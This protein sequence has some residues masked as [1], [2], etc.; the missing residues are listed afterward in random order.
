MKGVAN[1]SSSKPMTSSDG[2]HP[3]LRKHGVYLVLSDPFV[4]MSPV[5]VSDQGLHNNLRKD[6]DVP[7]LLCQTVF[8]LM[9]DFI[10]IA[11]PELG[12]EPATNSVAPRL[13]N[14]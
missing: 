14:W 1:T 2:W 8:F 3:C 5:C 9:K 12:N 4:G 7:L 10:W 11:I 6:I 13:E